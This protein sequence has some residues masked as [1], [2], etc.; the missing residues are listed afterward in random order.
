MRILNLRIV[1]A[2]IFA[3]SPPTI[4]VFL[5]RQVRCCASASLQDNTNSEAVTSTTAS[6][7][8]SRI[9]PPEISPYE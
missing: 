7:P 5:D 6:L 2:G 1:R 4:L 8:I 3:C 9:S